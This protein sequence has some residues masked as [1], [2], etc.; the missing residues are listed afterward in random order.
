MNIHEKYQGIHNTIK[1]VDMIERFIGKNKTSMKKHRNVKKKQSFLNEW[2]SE[3]KMCLVR[4]TECTNKHA[5]SPFT[6][7]VYISI[8]RNIFISQQWYYNEHCFKDKKN[9]HPIL[10]RMQRVRKQTS[11]ALVNS[12]CHAYQSI[13]TVFVSSEIA[14]FVLKPQKCV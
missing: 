13:A 7:C 5:K 9:M 6:T 12:C 8:F 1:L 4:F 11:Y 2:T 10:M 3:K 14:T